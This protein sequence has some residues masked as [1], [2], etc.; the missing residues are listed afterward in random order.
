MIL[1]R[2]IL[3]AFYI[4][5][6]ISSIDAQN[7]DSLSLTKLDSE[8]GDLDSDGIDELV[9]VYD[10]N[11]PTEFGNCR[12]LHIYKKNTN[13]SLINPPEWLLWKHSSSA[14]YPSD[15]GGGMGDPYD[16]IEIKDGIL[17]I[18]H[19]GGTSWKWTHIHKYRFQDGDFFLIGLT[20]N[21]FMN[22]RFMRSDYNLS[23]G[24]LVYTDK[25]DGLDDNGNEVKEIYVDET[26]YH[27]VALPRIDNI[28]IGEIEV[29]LPES[30]KVVYLF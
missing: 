21:S 23:T 25:L 4:L 11:I 28:V 7:L 16:G 22:P 17:S 27:K 3:T 5:I 13:S 30:G 8:L 24:K 18:A 10:S 15:S 9:V 2:N 26:I 1:R 29:T 14:V 12:I 19:F 6:T 20:K